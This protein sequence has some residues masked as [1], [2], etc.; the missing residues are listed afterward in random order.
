MSNVPPE[1][2]NVPPEDNVERGGMNISNRR[3]TVIACA[4]VFCLP[5]VV[6]LGQEADSSNP[7][8]VAFFESRIRPVLVK[9]CYACHSVQAGKSEGGLL[10]DNR[11]GLLKGGE[12]GPA[13][14]PGDSDSSLLISAIRHEDFEMPRDQA[15][16]SAE[17]ISDFVAWVTSGAPDP[18]KGPVGDHSTPPVH[19]R[20]TQLLGVSTAPGIGATQCS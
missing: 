17:V 13:V 14:E 12:S 2:S 16:L 20:R 18:R 6:T 11:S 1:D 8:N 4:V 15:Q 7:D 10:V 3:L 9:H 19:G 5:S